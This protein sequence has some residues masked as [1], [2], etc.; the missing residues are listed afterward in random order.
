M[1]KKSPFFDFFNRREGTDF[2]R[3]V[4]ASVE[5]E[6]YINW[7]ESLLAMDY[8]D[9]EAEYVAIRNSCALFD[10][11]PIRK[12][13]IRGAGAGAFLDRLLTRPVSI[14]SS[15][16]ATYTIFCN[17]D[18][19]LKDDSIL[20]KFADDDYI[21][22]PSDIDHSPY[23]ESLC[24]RFGLGDVTFTECTDAWVGIAVQGPYSA[25]VL[26]NMG[27][28]S[29]ADLK[30]FEVRDIAMSDGSVRV[31]R[32]GF[33]ADLGYECWF[34]PEMVNEFI[35]R[36]ES[37]RKTMDIAL[38]GYGLSALQACRLEG[39]FVVAGWDFSTEL[40]P[41]PGFE[42]SPFDIG[43]GWLVNLDAE[44]FV[45]RDALAKQKAEGHPFVL[46]GIEIDERNAPDDGTELFASEDIDAASI[47]MINCSNWSW[48]LNK[49]IG[50]ASLESTHGDI[51]EAWFTQAGNRVRVRLSRGPFINLERRNQVPAP[52]VL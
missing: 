10:V 49:T 41:Q 46:R 48:G 29:V 9:A 22:M 33:T 16:R 13:R 52:V 31:G 5:D 35:R 38:P 40:E 45:G 15:M 17:E 39:G 7:N 18:G 26:N 2:E 3:F 51:G 1:L 34:E 42:R 6:H 27:F 44:E 37:V 25:A 11:S 24:Q 4:A 14:L 47:G 28:E 23:F 36:L 21:L 19:S 50:N 20:Y 32:V 12:I 8:G 43:L 30:P